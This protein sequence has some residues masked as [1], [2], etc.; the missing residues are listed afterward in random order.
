MPFPEKWCGG[1]GGGWKGGAQV[2][3]DASNQQQKK[4]G[5][6]KAAALVVVSFAGS[7]GARGKT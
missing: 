1:V 7:C 6:K 2:G 5:Q 3:E 4:K